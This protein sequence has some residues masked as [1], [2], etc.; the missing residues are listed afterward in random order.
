MCV[1]AACNLATYDLADGSPHQIGLMDDHSQ[2]RTMLRGGDG[3]VVL[4]GARRGRQI[5]VLRLDADLR[6]SLWAPR[7]PGVS[8]A[9]EKIPEGPG[10]LLDHTANAAAYEDEGTVRILGLDGKLL[11]SFDA[12]TGG[13]NSFPLFRF[14]GQDRLLFQGGGRLTVRDYHGKVLRTLGKLAQG[15]GSRIGRSADGNRLLFD[16]L[17]RHV[18]WV[19]SIK[20]K[21][22]VLPTMGMSAD[23]EVPNGETVHVI[24]TQSGKQCFEW[25]G[26]ATS[27]PLRGAHA[28]IDPSGRLVAIVTHE[29]LAI[30]HL[31]DACGVR[32]ADEH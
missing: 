7:V 13:R 11:G 26:D 5:G 29:S 22:M 9:G 21:A 16:M 4:N 3:G 24:E 1:S 20:E 12:A 30:Y 28:D 25:K 23:G 2:Y 10:R 17:T 18:G 14:L 31:P 15:W 8:P 27:L 32:R 6:T 19:Q